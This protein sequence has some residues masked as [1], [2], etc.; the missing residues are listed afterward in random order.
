MTITVSLP[1]ETSKKL[2][3]RAAETGKDVATLIREAV[4]EKLGVARAPTDPS[5][6]PYVEW[7]R[8]FDAWVERR[9]PVGHFVDDSRESIYAGRGE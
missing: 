4:N 6:L 8:A 9:H 5:D 7:R 2:K 1:D 3:E